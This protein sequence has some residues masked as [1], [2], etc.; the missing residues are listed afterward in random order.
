MYGLTYEQGTPLTVD[1][2]KGR[3]T[4]CLEETERDMFLLGISELAKNGFEQYEISNFAKSC[5]ESKHNQK[6]WDGSLFLGL[7]PSAHSFDGKNRWANFADFQQYHKFL[8]EKN[9]PIEYS[10]ELT[11]E[12]V[13]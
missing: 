6:Y 5:Y 11:S 1:F 13:T 7:G 4:K 3:V 2:E 8:S 10:E 12:I 9:L